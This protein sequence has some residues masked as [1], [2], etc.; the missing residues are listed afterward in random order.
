[1]S[2]IKNR[3]VETVKSI[4]RNHKVVLL[5]ILK[6]DVNDGYEMPIQKD[7]YY[8]LNT[9]RRIYIPAM[10]K[11]IMPTN[12]MSLDEYLSSLRSMGN[13]KTDTISLPDGTVAEAYNIPVNPMPS[14]IE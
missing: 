1:M 2:C 14:T 10:D 8:L 7:H 3:K 6:S 13:L 5:K 4:M 12:R 9:I 11:G